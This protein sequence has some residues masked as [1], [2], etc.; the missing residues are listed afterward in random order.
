GALGALSL[1]N[2]RPG[3]AARDGMVLARPGAARADHP[4]RRLNDG[5]RGAVLRLRQVPARDGAGPGALR[6]R[7]DLAHRRGRAWTTVSAPALLAGRA[8]DGGPGG[9]LAARA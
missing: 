3:G 7:R 5:Q 2:A 6:G 9:Q 4:D 1:R 8:G